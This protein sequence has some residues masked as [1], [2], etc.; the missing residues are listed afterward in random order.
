M[1]KCKKC[2]KTLTGDDTKYSDCYDCYAKPQ[3]T[4]LDRFKAFFE[5][6]GISCEQEST[7]KEIILYYEDCYT[8]TVDFPR[9]RV[10]LMFDKDGNLI[11]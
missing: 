3:T 2:G 9:H 8:K 11:K 10:L 7:G 4:Q 6:E 5:R 1:S